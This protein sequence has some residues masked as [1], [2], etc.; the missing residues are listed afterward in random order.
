MLECPLESNTMPRTN[1]RSPRLQGPAGTLDNLPT[2]S[3][4]R[5]CI[6]FEVCTEL[7]EVC[8]EDERCSIGTPNRFTPRAVIA[9][10][11]DITLRL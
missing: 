5:D 3:H 8:A 6:H 9:A 1:H 2:G 7:F 10:K 11:P 4:C